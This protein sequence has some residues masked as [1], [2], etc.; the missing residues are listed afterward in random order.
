MDAGAHL[1]VA[2]SPGGGWLK[3]A[4]ELG[5]A[6]AAPSGWKLVF[7]AHQAPATL[8]QSSY[9]E[10]TMNQDIGFPAVAAGLTASGG[11]VWL[12]TTAAIDEADADIERWRDRLLCQFF[13]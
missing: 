1:A 7:N 13:G 9:S 11:V 2:A 5:G 4:D 12:T 10:T 8:G 3:E 6:A